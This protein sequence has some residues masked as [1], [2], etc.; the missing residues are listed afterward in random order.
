MLTSVRHEFVEHIPD[1]LDD[2]VLYVSIRFGTVVHRCACGC[3]Q[4]VVTPLGPAEWRLTYDGRS[5]SLAPSIGNWSF[6]CQ[7][8]YW[9]E[10]GRVRWARGF[11][12][13]EVGRSDERREPGVTAISGPGKLI[14]LRMSR[15]NLSWKGTGT[16]KASLVAIDLAQTLA[17]RAATG[18]RR[19]V[20]ARGWSGH[21]A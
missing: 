7:S 5:V 12:E 6:S 21:K 4:E 16:T 18:S 20:D 19:K 14:F 15:R 1:E 13:D 8:H 9:I 17:D 11:S 3:G 2:G 10:A